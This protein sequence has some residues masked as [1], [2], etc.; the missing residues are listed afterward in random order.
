MSVSSVGLANISP[1]DRLAAL[2]MKLSKPPSPAASAL[3]N[4]ANE[5]AAAIVSISPGAQA[6]ARGFNENQVRQA[7]QFAQ[8]AAAISEV[9]GRRGYPA[10]R[11]Y[12]QLLSIV[13]RGRTELLFICDD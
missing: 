9:Q 7:E 13:A 6:R 10:S 11:W 1:Y 3:P 4:E 8:D 2:S 12:K 5:S